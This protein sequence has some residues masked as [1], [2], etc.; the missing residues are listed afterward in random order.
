MISVAGFGKVMHDISL[1]ACAACKCGV[2]A[3]MRSMQVQICA[4]AVSMRGMQ[5]QRLCTQDVCV[6]HK[7][8]EWSAG[9]MR[10][11]H[12]TVWPYVHMDD[13][14]CLHMYIYIYM[15]VCLYIS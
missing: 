1:Q 14:L 10:G 13:V 5:V 8:H 6:V 3:S 15:Y 4:Q 7:M 12:V 2:S 11:M 9:C